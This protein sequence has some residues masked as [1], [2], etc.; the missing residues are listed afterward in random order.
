MTGKGEVDGAST[1]GRTIKLRIPAAVGTTAIDEIGTA[2]TD[3]IE[4]IADDAAI[5]GHMMID[6]DISRALVR[7]DITSMSAAVIQ[8][9]ADAAVAIF[10]PRT[11]RS[12]WVG[13]RISKCVLNHDV[14]EN[15]SLRCIFQNAAPDVL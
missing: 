8:K 15:Q 13:S 7:R 3:M 9:S 12:A 2:M 10:V 1:I 6:T 4:T 14:D 5:R 11:T